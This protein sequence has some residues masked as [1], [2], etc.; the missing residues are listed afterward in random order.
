MSAIDDYL[1]ETVG[2]L[3]HI[4]REMGGDSFRGFFMGGVVANVLANLSE[5]DWEAFSN[6]IPCGRPA[7]DCHLVFVDLLNELKALREDHKTHCPKSIVE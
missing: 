4:A 3:L 2:G 6:P 1:K 7:C 5:K